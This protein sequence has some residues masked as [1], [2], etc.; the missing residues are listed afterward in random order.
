MT[1]SMS[2]DTVDLVYTVDMVYIVDM[3]YAVGTLLYYLN[4]FTLLQSSSTY[5]YM[6]IYIVQCAI[7]LGR[8][9]SDQKVGVDELDKLDSIQWISL[10]LL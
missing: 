9:T 10:N 1:N 5:V 7:G 6:P 2:V 3:V 4:Y 8:C